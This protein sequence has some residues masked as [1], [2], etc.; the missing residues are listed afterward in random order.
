M[1]FLTLR[2]N[3][4]SSLKLLS[5]KACEKRT[6]PDTAVRRTFVKICL[7]HEECENAG[8]IYLAHVGK[9]VQ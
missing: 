5:V 6:L 9:S 2:I 8:Q 4:K 7:K 1:A 3:T